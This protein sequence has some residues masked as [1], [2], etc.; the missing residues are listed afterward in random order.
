MDSKTFADLEGHWAQSDIELLAAKRIINGEAPNRFSP[1]K[2]I[3]RAE[4]TAILVRSLGLRVPNKAA[5]FSDVAKG[6]WFTDVIATAV[7]AGIVN[8]Y[9]DGSFK[10]NEQVTR[11]QMAVML[12]R[13]LSYVNKSVEVNENALE[14]YTDK[15]SIS[16]WAKPAIDELLTSQIMKGKSDTTIDPAALASRAEAAVMIKRFLQFVQFIN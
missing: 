10:P 14:K 3:T 1:D 11:E 16:A 15:G 9:T 6:D 12:A 13:A 7:E 8:G 5:T 4:F 2:S